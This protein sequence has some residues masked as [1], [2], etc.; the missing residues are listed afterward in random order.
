VRNH[1]GSRRIRGLG[2]GA[3]AVLA[4]GG[5]LLVNPLA[6]TAATTVLTPSSITT[7]SGTTGS[8]E[9]VGNLAEKDLTGSTDGWNKY[10]EFAGRYS[11]YLAY[12]VPD[13]IAVTS[14]SGLAVQVNYRGPGIRTQ[15]WTFQ[16]RNWTTNSWVTVGDNATAPDWG[17][18]KLLTFHTSGRPADYVSSSR[19]LRLRLWAGNDADAADIDYA[20]VVLTTSPSSAPSSTP[21]APPSTRPSGSPTASPPASPSPAPPS[22]SHDVT[23]PS[24]PTHLAV[25]ATTATSASL[26]WTGST[27]NVAVTG[28]EVFQGAGTT[29]VATVG[30]TSTTVSGLSASTAYT[31][32]VKARDAAGN[33]SAA[34]AGVVATTSAASS[35]GL[36]ATVACAGCWHPGLRVSWNWVLDHVPA[37]PYRAVQMYDIDGFDAQAADVTALHSAGI[38]AVCYLSVGSYENWRPDA[39]QFPASLL[40]DDLDGWAGERWLDIRDVQQP[41]SQLAQIMSARLDMCRSKGFDAVEF[42]NMDG[43]TNKTGFPLTAAQ[44]AYYDAFLANGAHQRGMSAVMKNDLDQVTTLLPYFDVALNEQCNEYSEC[45]PLSEFVAAGKPVFNAEYASSTG[46]CAADNAANFNGLNL[47]LELDDSKFQPCR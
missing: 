43:Y 44:Q 17:A 26:S 13:N 10:V 27:D 25:T 46:F 24:V 19:A 1:F 2:V 41:G 28:Y 22:P 9:R 6:A 23:A 3:V 18:W 35:G 31:F 4:T 11:G 20:A 32:T 29:A 39:A 15:S 14:I 38:K 30:G 37:A 36:P 34:S 45:S 40:G 8:G 12:S 47:A 7:S 5:F 33:R 21:A 16:L 42:D